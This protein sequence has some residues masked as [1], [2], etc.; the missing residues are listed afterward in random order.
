MIKAAGIS[1]K[2]IDA[3]LR[4]S[5]IGELELDEN[6]KAKNGE[7]ITKKI[8]EEFSDF[9]VTTD[10]KGAEFATPPGDDGKTDLG[11]LSMEEYIAERKKSMKG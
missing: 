3:V 2:R 9:V 5:N 8:K 11:K 1:E 6:G 7:D 10:E 4:I